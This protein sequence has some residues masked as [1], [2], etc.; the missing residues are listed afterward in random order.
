MG[1]DRASIV[2]L[3]VSWRWGPGT[4]GSPK[5]GPQASADPASYAD[6]T[7]AHVLPESCPPNRVGTHCTA[8]T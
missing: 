5:A 2:G 6:L 4:T 1:A 8:A 3:R 7:P